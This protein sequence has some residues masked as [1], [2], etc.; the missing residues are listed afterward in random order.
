[1]SVRDR[2]GST[3]ARCHSHDGMRRQRSGDGSTRMPA[4]TGPGAGSPCARISCRHAR[5]ASSPVTFCSSTAEAIASKTWLVRMR[6]SADSRRCASRSSGCAETSRSDQSSPSPSSSGTPAMAHSAPGPQARA[7]TPPSA[8][9][10]SRSDA[11]PSGVRAVRQTPTRRDPGVTGSQ[12]HVGSTTPRNSGRSTSRRSTS[13]SGR[14]VVP[15]SG[16]VTSAPPW[17]IPSGYA[18]PPTPPGRPPR[19]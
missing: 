12:R 11:S 2:F 3:P 14:Y 9:G 1:M 8:R 10:S 18:R 4:G 15:A 13:R 17:S 6:R 16:A 7:S 19:A 5:L